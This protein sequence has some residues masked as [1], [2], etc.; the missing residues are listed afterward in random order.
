MP[1]IANLGPSLDTIF[2]NCAQQP[3]RGVSGG[4][5]CPVIGKVMRPSRIRKPTVAIPFACSSRS[6]SVPSASLRSS[7]LEFLP[8]STASVHAD[9]AV[10]II[11]VSLNPSHLCCVIVVSPRRPHDCHVHLEF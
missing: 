10:F 5:L 3:N 8:P 4:V 9:V 2:F 6:H 7:F 11:V 1:L